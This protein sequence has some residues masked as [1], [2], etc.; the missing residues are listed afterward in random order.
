VTN[1]D[2]CKP[3]VLQNTRFQWMHLITVCIEFT[4]WFKKNGGEMHDCELQLGV[5]EG[6]G[7]V[8]TKDIKVVFCILNC[9]QQH[10]V[11]RMV[12]Q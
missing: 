10:T 1:C 2:D 9:M 3:L 6:N 12:H 8:A 5:A 11:A 7:I 4:A